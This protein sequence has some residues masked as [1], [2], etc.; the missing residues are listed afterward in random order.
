MRFSIRGVYSTALTTY[1]LDRGHELVNPTEKQ[2]M[3]FGVST[4]AQ[5]D[6]AISDTDDREGIIVKGGIDLI[7]EVVEELRQISWQVVSSPI[8]EKGLVRLY[9]PFEAKEELDKIRGRTVY[10]VPLHHYCRAGGEA[11]SSLITLCE[12]VVAGGKAEKGIVEE[13]VR[14]AVLGLLPRRGDVIFLHHQKPHRRK[15]VLGP[16]RS[17]KKGNPLILERTIRGFGLYDGLRVEKTPGDTAITTIPRL[18]WSMQTRYVGLGNRHKGSYINISTPIHVYDNHV[19]YLDLGIDVVERPESRLEV[20]DREELEMLLE[21][22]CISRQLYDRALDEVQ[23][24][25]S[26]RA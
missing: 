19:W 14:E 22:G 12:E 11:L 4:I 10:T 13:K 16:Y 24:Y 2:R 26:S 9:F 15:I 7:R 5:P 3:L 17:V 25:L 20:I 6:V 23:R 18:G 1:L 8:S 21:A